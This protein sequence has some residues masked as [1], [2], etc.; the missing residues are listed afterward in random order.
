MGLVKSLGKDWIDLPDEES[1]GS[2][3][4][5]RKSQISHKSGFIDAVLPEYRDG[6]AKRVVDFSSGNGVL[7]EIFRYY[8]HDVLGIDLQYFAFLKSQ[9]IPSL[10][11]DCRHL[12]FPL[13]DKSCDLITCVGSISTYGDVHWGVILSEFARIARECI[14][15]RPNQG[16][17]LNEKRHELERWVM[18][19]WE[20]QKV[21]LDN[22]KWKYNV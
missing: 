16:P 8:G 18:P 14:V 5:N 15:V 11:H 6:S 22:Y 10:E 4:R 3:F 19:G 7:L 12:P 17:V 13:T 9:G 1:P 20:S 21:T 2:R